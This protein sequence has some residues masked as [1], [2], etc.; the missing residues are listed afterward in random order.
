LND[1]GVSISLT[2]RV[3]SVVSLSAMRLRSFICL[4]RTATLAVRDMFYLK[5][6]FVSMELENILSIFI[7]HLKLYQPHLLFE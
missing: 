4:Y 7:H 3:L 1:T 6:N 2:R 5:I